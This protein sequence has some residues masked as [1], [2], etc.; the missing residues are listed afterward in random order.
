M[1]PVR[2]LLRVLLGVTLLL[3][4]FL[5]AELPCESLA[6]R[7]LG[8]MGVA[9]NSYAPAEGKAERDGWFIVGCAHE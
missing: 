8:V 2:V 5:G 4:P 7:R 3:P 9:E 1:R 6:S